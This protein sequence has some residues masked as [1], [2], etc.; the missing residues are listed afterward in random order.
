M[1][2]GAIELALNELKLADHMIQVTL[3]LLN[4]RMIFINAV[5]HVY[6][7]VKRVINEF[8]QK[9]FDYKRLDILPKEEERVA[10]FLKEYILKLRL[11]DY[12][13]VINKLETFNKFKNRSSVKL[14]RNDKFVIITP[15]YETF[16][17]SETEIK[18]Y[19]KKVELFLNNIK[20]KL[21]E[22]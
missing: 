13:D 20:D 9:E 3:P 16:S 6:N 1:K 12:N 7:A 17:I 8:L 14:Q 10:L 4:D 21:Y 5:S 19:I 11:K 2:G 18:A 15:E 22:R